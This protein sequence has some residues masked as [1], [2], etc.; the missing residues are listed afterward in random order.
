M[1]FAPLL[2][3]PAP[4]QAVQSP[5]PEGDLAF[6]RVRVTPHY[7]SASPLENV[8]RYLAP[9]EDG[10]K[11]EKYAFEIGTL[12]QDWGRAL[13][14]DPPALN[15]LER[16]VASQAEFSVLAP[17]QEIRLRAKSG[18]EI[19]RREFSKE[20][21]SGREQMLA[22]FK[23]YLQPWARLETAEFELVG[24]EASGPVLQINIRYEFAGIRNDRKREARAGQWLTQWSQTQSRSWQLQ[25]LEATREDS[26]P[27]SGSRCFWT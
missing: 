23:A 5:S 19:F 15:V 21:A 4:L 22:Q 8:L 9:G 25:S 27:R 16:F 13:R 7:P 17:V 2:F 24:I 20:R 14:S 18:I 12:L 1:R 26:Q 10:Y 11:T 3:L 6:S